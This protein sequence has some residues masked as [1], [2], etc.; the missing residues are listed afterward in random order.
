[1]FERVGCTLVFVLLTVFC[2][3]FFF[4]RFLPSLIGREDCY[5]NPVFSF[6][7]KVFFRLFLWSSMLL[8]CYFLS[9]YF[10]P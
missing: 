8:G 5:T 2:F 9:F 7:V 10:L 3:S 4:G 1:M 6:V